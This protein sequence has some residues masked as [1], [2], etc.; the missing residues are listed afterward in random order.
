MATCIIT[1]VYANLKFQEFG[2]HKSHHNAT[3]LGRVPHGDVRLRGGCQQSVTS[4]R[5]SQS[6]RQAARGRAESIGSD[7]EVAGGGEPAEEDAWEDPRMNQTWRLIWPGAKGAGLFNRARSEAVSGGVRAGAGGCS[8]EWVPEGSGNSRPGAGRG[9]RGR[10]H[11]AS[12]H[13][14]SPRRRRTPRRAAPRASP[15]LQ[16]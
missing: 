4:R 15:G 16:W 6:R 2:E 14:V 10:A 7:A 9:P 5:V 11:R 13:N 3:P 8:S 1:D 12:H